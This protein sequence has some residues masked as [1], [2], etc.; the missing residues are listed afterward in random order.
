MAKGFISMRIAYFD[1]FS[2]ISGDMTLGALVDAG[3]ELEA[4]KS[5]LYQLPLGKFRIQAFPVRRGSFAGTKVEIITEAEDQ[6]HRRLQ[7][8]LEIIGK[9]PLPETVKKDSERIFVRLAEAEAKV[10]G[11]SV[12]K[13][14]FHEVGALDS[15]VDVIGAALGI[16]LLG[17]EKIYASSLNLGSGFVDAEH[18]RLPVPA[19]GTLELVR[20]LPTYSTNVQAELTTPTG[21][22]IVSTLCT[23]FGPLPSME[24]EKIGYGAGSLDLPGFPNMLR[25]IVGQAREAYQEDQVMVIEA[26]LDDMS[27]Q[28]FE[29]LV[30]ELFEKGALDVYL[31]SVIMKKSRPAVKLTVIAEGALAE[32]C[33]SLILS[34]TTTFGVRSYP[35]KRRK[36][37]REVLE[38]NTPYGPIRVKVG[39][40]GD[41]IL[42]LNPEYEDCKRIA[43]ERGL[44]VITI[45]REAERAAWDASKELI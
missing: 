41:R 32:T 34:N 30:D 39:R 35:V 43:Q 17:I 19:P 13:V 33:T 7:D 27:P 40:S 38:I 5:Q 1:C 45:Y 20:G 8:I 25:L 26:N 9:S 16:H 31:S 18:G 24:I 44:P 23:G 4:L 12:D 14:H 36:L 29:P 28:F 21:A 11:V 3:L 37:S 15:I 22:A 10:H 2:G 42:H 6:S